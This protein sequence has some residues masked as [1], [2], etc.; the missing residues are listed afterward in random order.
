MPTLTA[1]PAICYINRASG[2][3]ITAT[4]AASGYA[5]SNLNNARMSSS[6]RST[7]LTAQ[8]LVADLTS[9][10][11]ID[12]IALLGFNG[13]DDATLTAKT[14]E[15]SDLSSHE[16]SSGSV[17]AFD[18]TYT[19]KLSDTP[20]YGRH[21]ITFP[22]TTQNSR[23]VGYDTLNDSGNPD[24][25]LQ[26]RVLWAGPVWQP[27]YGMAYESEMLEEMVGNPGAERYLRIWKLTLKG[28]TEAQS[29][30]LLSILRNKLRSGR[31]LIVPRPTLTAT[32]VNEAIYATLA[33]PAKRRA[34]PTKTVTWSVDVAFREVED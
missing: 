33:E 11:D 8:R 31:Y 28:L 24:T 6:W 13:E 1:A 17:N 15:N 30:E 26:G 3:T 12:V 9:A 32:F 14:S 19:A 18:T 10:T 16:Y 23:Y 22:G 29:R 2:K 25:Y 21:T 20:V 7:A 34:M 5:A 27:P 4:T